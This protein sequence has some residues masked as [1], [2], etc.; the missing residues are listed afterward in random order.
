[1]KTINIYDVVYTGDVPKLKVCDRIQVIN[2]KFE[3]SNCMNILNDYAGLSQLPIEHVYLASID[4]LNRINGII[5]I[6]E[7]NE[8]HA[9]MS[10]RKITSFLL[11]L[12]S[13]HYLMVHNHPNDAMYAS[14]DD[15][16]SAMMMETI[17]GMIEITFEGSYIAGKTGYVKVTTLWGGK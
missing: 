17:A 11:L 7:G 5:K 13:S 15:I 8:N 6:A 1:M 9:E 2:N 12:G 10:K 4:K 16:M 14:N 3:I